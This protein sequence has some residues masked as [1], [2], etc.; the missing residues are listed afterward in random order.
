MLAD[1]AFKMCRETIASIISPNEVKY[2]IA[3]LERLEGKSNAAGTSN[4]N[5]YGRELHDDLMCVDCLGF[6]SSG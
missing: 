4:G 3:L 6:D 1:H 5:E 2:W